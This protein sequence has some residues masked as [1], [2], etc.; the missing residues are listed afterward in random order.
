MCACMRAYASVYLKCVCVCVC[1][2]VHASVCILCVYMRV[3]ECM[4]IHMRVCA[5]VILYIC[6]CISVCVFEYGYVYTCTR[7]F[8]RN[9]TAS[10]TYLI[11][12]DCAYIKNF[13]C[14]KYR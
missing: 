8:I 7:T 3:S 11:I 5:R 12:H 10:D 9:I 4:H 6:A 2:C 14:Q 1:V 13:M